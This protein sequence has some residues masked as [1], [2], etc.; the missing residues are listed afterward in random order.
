[1]LP[2]LLLLL[3][4]IALPAGDARLFRLYCPIEEETVVQVYRDGDKFYFAPGDENGDSSSTNNA[5]ANNVRRRQNVL[6][7]NWNT[8]FLR[9]GRNEDIISSS[10]TS[11]LT[12]EA[13]R[14]QTQDVSTLET[15]S[16]RKC[17]CAWGR[18]YEGTDYYCTLP[19]THCGIPSGTMIPKVPLRD[20]DLD[21]SSLSP[22]SI[23][24]S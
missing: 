2:S 6:E 12:I 17:S 24:S 19:W 10:T 18:H 21:A 22:L 13:S 7:E 5:G 20:D 1:M 11:A 4:A 3:L 9:G 23:Y 14:R 8:Q 16:V 15:V